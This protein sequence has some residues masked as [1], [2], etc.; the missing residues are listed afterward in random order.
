LSFWSAY[1]DAAPDRASYLRYA[2]LLAAGY[3][4]FYGW[5]LARSALFPYVMDNN[6]SFSSLWHASNLYHFGLSGSFG[7]TDEAYGFEPGAHP[8]VYTHQGNLPRLF[9]LVLY[10]LGARTIESQILVTTFTIGLAA[11]FLAFWFL[12]HVT[13]N[14]GF[15]ALACAV[16]FS[17]YVL[18]AQWQVV[19]YRVWHAFFVFSTFSCVAALEGRHRWRVFAL[20]TL[21]AICSISS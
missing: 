13:R 17:D 14:R 20:L 6:E 2:A 11:V 5:L 1:R 4:L 19:T 7:L 9:A 15:A 12:S 8:Y 10:G 3:I 18:V 16:I 21:N